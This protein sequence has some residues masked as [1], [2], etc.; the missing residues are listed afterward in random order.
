MEVEGQGHKDQEVVN[1]PQEQESSTMG[2]QVNLI[3]NPILSIYFH[4]VEGVCI[5]MI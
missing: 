4:L 1:S 3:R 2:R 5:N